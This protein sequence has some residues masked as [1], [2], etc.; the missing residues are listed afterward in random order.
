MSTTLKVCK[1]LQIERKLLDF[2]IERLIKFLNAPVFESLHPIQKEALLEQK[3]AMED[4]SNALIKRINQLKEDCSTENFLTKGEEIIGSFNPSGN[5]IA[6]ETKLLSIALIN[7][8]ETVG[9]CP[10]RKAKAI[11]DIETGTMFAVK[12]IFY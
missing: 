3:K 6:E 2:K 10:R 9:K 5:D 11:T 12:S 7:F 8:V 4:Y 1:G